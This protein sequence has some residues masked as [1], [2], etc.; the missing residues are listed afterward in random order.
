MQPWLA[1]PL[2]AERWNNGCGPHQQVCSLLTVQGGCSVTVVNT[3]F[4]SR[5]VLRHTELESIGRRAGS[6]ETPVARRR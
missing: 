6:G 5:P 3:V 1:L 2:S 4:T